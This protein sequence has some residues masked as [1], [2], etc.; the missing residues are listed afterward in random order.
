MTNQLW[1]IEQEVQGQWLRV[2]L[3]AGATAEIA[4]TRCR[5]ICDS[6]GRTLWP[7][8]RAELAATAQPKGA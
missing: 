2:G 4:I 1:L 7:N 3:Y 8:L 5:R 6:Q